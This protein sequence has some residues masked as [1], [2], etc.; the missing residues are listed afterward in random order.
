[1]RFSEYEDFYSTFR[2]LSDA[3]VL[4][5]EELNRD[6][7]RRMRGETPLPRK[8]WGALRGSQG[9]PGLPKRVHTFDATA[10]IGLRV[11]L[12]SLKVNEVRAGSQAS[13]VRTGWRLVEI[14][15]EPTRSAKDLKRAIDKLCGDSKQVTTTWKFEVPSKGGDTSAIPP[16]SV[17]SGQKVK[18][19]DKC[20][21]ACKLTTCNH[22]P[23]IAFRLDSNRDYVDLHGR[24][25][26]P[27]PM[28]YPEPD[29]LERVKLDQTGNFPQTG[30]RIPLF[31]EA[32]EEADGAAVQ[33]DTIKAVKFPPMAQ[34]T[35][36][37]GLLPDPKEPLRDLENA[38]KLAKA[39]V[40]KQ[41]TRETTRLR[42][43]IKGREAQ[44][45][46]TESELATLK[47]AAEYKKSKEAEVEKA[48]KEMEFYKKKAAQ[49]QRQVRQSHQRAR[50]VAPPAPAYVL[51]RRYEQESMDNESLP[52]YRT[53]NGD[54]S[55]PEYASNASLAPSEPRIGRGENQLP[56]P[57]PTL[58]EVGK[59]MPQ[60]QLESMN[61]SKE[62][63]EPASSGWWDRLH[64]I[65]ANRLA[66]R[67]GMYEEGNAARARKEEALVEKRPK[68][69]SWKEK[70]NLNKVISK[71]D[72]LAREDLFN[73]R[74]KKRQEGEKN[75]LRK[76]RGRPVWWC[77]S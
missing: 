63:L 75:D 24:Y 12:K 45:A 48:T 53:S 50:G 43:E 20:G 57:P 11:N 68:A 52:S 67:D 64:G 16:L 15:G 18:L 28:Y 46:K 76:R 19:D 58:D 72:H 10:P 69:P 2:V 41:N 29:S 27:E 74:R 21:Q 71:T 77:S 22:R 3:E 14:D 6:E 65:H 62:P 56:P 9:K 4:D 26:E 30:Q 25:K 23:R 37:H 47:A 13:T 49:L 66:K 1:M 54:H 61:E 32:W 59:K 73:E 8:P 17:I 5:D 39:A 33:I 38:Y 60:E 55:L 35:E 40:R 51:S 36:T 7:V 31:G 42:K 44:L 70:E 34:D